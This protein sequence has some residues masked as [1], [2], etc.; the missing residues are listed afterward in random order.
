M[1]KWPSWRMRP[2]ILNL[3][4]RTIICVIEPVPMVIDTLSATMEAWSERS[5][6]RADKRG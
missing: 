2:L 5:R 4:T 3:L 1:R 6:Y